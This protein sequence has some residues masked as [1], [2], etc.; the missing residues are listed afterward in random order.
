MKVNLCTLGPKSNAPTMTMWTLLFIEVERTGY[1]MLWEWMTSQHSPEPPGPGLA[2]PS[3]NAETP[4]RRPTAPSAAP[5]TAAPRPWPSSARRLWR[6]GWW[7]PLAVARHPAQLR[8]NHYTPAPAPGCECRPGGGPASSPAA[9][10]P[11]LKET[12]R[13]TTLKVRSDFICG[14]FH[15]HWKQHRADCQPVNTLVF[16]MIYFEPFLFKS[17]SEKLFN[18]RPSLYKHLTFR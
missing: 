8:L 5:R 9:G 15:L 4:W 3:G 14:S 16:Q 2:R 10:F 11:G 18:I 1:I 17:H 6:S 7:C 12:R 13:R